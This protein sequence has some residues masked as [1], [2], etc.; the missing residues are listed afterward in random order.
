MKVFRIK[1]KEE[2]KAEGKEKKPVK[3]FV[4]CSTKKLRIESK[5]GFDEFE[6]DEVPAEV[7]SKIK[8]K[9]KINF[10]KAKKERKDEKAKKEAD[11]KKKKNGKIK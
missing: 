6:A 10:E 7:E 9:D 4:F 2:E 3:D 5:S 11:E 8:V 1:R